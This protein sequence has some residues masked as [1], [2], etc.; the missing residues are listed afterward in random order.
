MNL[1]A[2]FYTAGIWMIL[3]AIWQAGYRYGRVDPSNK[4]MMRLGV[5][6]VP[7]LILALIV[8]RLA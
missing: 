7:G 1:A 5:D 3:T 4:V 2:A 6:V 8:A